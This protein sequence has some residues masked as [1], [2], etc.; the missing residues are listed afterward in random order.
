MQGQLDSIAL[1]V[2]KG[3]VSNN[4]S[5]AALLASAIKH[6][7]VNGGVPSDSPHVIGIEAPQPGNFTVPH[8]LGCYPSAAVVQM[9]SAGLIYFQ[10]PKEYDATNLYLAASDSKLTAQILIWCQQ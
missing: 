10:S 3:G 8:G 9:N 2:G 4:A 5:D 7:A 6:I 1:M